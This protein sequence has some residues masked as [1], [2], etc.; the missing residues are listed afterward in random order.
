LAQA[1][2]EIEAVI[3]G[4]GRL[5]AGQQQASDDNS[6]FHEYLNRMEPCSGA[7]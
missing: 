6:A 5:R 4:N 3:G 7:D 2:A 1:G